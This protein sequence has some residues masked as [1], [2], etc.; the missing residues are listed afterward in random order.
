MNSSSREAILN[1]VRDALGRKAGDP[2]PVPPPVRL[3]VPELDTAAR[4]AGFRNRFEALNG[5]VRVVP[6]CDAAREA[7]MEILNSRAAIASNAP[8]LEAC[9]ITRLESVRAGFRER[10][11]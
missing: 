8:F 5:Q 6:S 9:G 11:E 4:V 2:V 1:K 10:E 3:D 7:V